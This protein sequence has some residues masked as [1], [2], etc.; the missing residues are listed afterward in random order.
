MPAVPVPSSLC[1]GR[2]DLPGL[3]LL[4]PEPV[5]GGVR[6][7]NRSDVRSASPPQPLFITDA[8]AFEIALRKGVAISPVDALRM[9]Y[10]ALVRG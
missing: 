7:G 9:A 4:L 2:N 1:R 5:G 10:V 3:F 6:G 8:G